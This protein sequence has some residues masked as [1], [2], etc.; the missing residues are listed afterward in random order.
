MAVPGRR[1]GLM[2]EDDEN[3]EVLFEELIQEV[4]ETP[5]HLRDLAFAAE[6]GDVDALRRALGLA[7]WFFFFF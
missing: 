2:E 1:N 7:L 6:L 3:E 5:A 4:V